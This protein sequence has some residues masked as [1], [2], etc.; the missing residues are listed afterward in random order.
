VRYR[1]SIRRDREAFSL[2][3]EGVVAPGRR[4]VGFGRSLRLNI[5]LGTRGV[6]IDAV[7]NNPARAISRVE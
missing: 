1:H 2:V 7:T 4:L 3:N 6:T 5:E